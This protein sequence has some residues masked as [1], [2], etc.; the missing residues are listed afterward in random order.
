[1]IILTLMLIYVLCLQSSSAEPGPLSVPLV[2]QYI[3]GYWQKEP[4]S[5]HEAKLPNKFP[6]LFK[7]TSI[8]HAIINDLDTIGNT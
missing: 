1:M 8:T 2:P 5:C 7:S 3:K 4:Y 6:V